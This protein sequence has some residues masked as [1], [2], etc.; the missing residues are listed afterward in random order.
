MVAVDKVFSDHLWTFPFTITRYASFSPLSP[1]SA[2]LVK[3]AGRGR[4][5]ASSDLSQSV[6][7]NFAASTFWSLDPS[8]EHRIHF[9]DGNEIRWDYFLIVVWDSSL[10]FLKLSN[11]EH[12]NVSMND[13]LKNTL[14]R[15]NDIIVSTASYWAAK[16]FEG[17]VERF[18][19]GDC[20]LAANGQTSHLLLARRI[21]QWNVSLEKNLQAGQL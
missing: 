8:S 4:E 20:W 14:F 1:L 16:R 6:C 17:L 11:F 9:F 3:H 2:V 21:C 13:L 10:T 12:F 15:F 5:F 18:G 7:N 19:D